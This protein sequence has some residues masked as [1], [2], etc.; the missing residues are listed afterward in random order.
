LSTIDD[1]HNLIYYGWVHI[2][3]FVNGNSINNYNFEDMLIKNW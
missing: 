3:P 1:S 2:I